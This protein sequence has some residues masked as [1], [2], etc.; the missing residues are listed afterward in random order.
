MSEPLAWQTESL[1][2]GTQGWDSQ[3]ALMESAARDLRG[4]SCAALP[5]SVRG[6]ATTFLSRWAGYAEESTSIAR[7]FVGAL[8]ATADDYS[9]SDDAVD[10]RFSDL[11]GR[12]GPAR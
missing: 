6:A 7:G 11:D 2:R 5:P 12:L 4:A 8:R 10:R 9:T 3:E 1:R